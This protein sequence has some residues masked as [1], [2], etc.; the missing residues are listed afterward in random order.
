MR[1]R[2]IRIGQLKG[3]VDS[4]EGD[5]DKAGGHG[6]QPGVPGAPQHV[7]QGPD[8]VLIAVFVDKVV[9]PGKV[10]GHEDASGLGHDVGIGGQMCHGLAGKLHRLAG[11]EDGVELT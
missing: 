8:V 5:P 1:T 3:V 2:K 11:S 9:L 6:C 10:P 4:E 7:L